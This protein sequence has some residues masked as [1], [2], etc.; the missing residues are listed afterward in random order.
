[1]VTSGMLTPSQRK[2]PYQKLRRS[3]RAT[4]NTHLEYAF[5]SSYDYDRIYYWENG[6]AQAALLHPQR[7]PALIDAFIEG[8]TQRRRALTQEE[9]DT[10]EKLWNGC[11][12]RTSG[13]AARAFGVFGARAP[14]LAESL[15]DI[16]NEGLDPHHKMWASAH[17]ESS[18]ETTGWAYLVDEAVLVLRDS[19]NK[20]SPKHTDLTWSLIESLESGA[21][22]KQKDEALASLARLEKDAHIIPGSPA[23]SLRET[24]LK[25]GANAWT[26]KTLQRVFA[27]HNAVSN[28]EI[29]DTT[30]H[31]DWTLGFFRK[32]MVIEQA[33][34]AL[35][36][37]R[38]ANIFKPVLDDILSWDA[39]AQALKHFANLGVLPWNSHLIPQLQRCRTP[40]NAEME[41]WLGAI[42]AIAA[43]HPP[44]TDWLLEQTRTWFQY[45]F[46]RLLT[47][48]KKDN[49]QGADEAG[50]SWIKQ[51]GLIAKLNRWGD[52]S[53]TLISTE[54]LK[55]IQDPLLAINTR[56]HDTLL[57]SLIASETLGSFLLIVSSDNPTA[58]K[59]MPWRTLIDEPYQQWWDA[60]KDTPQWSTLCQRLWREIIAIEERENDF[61]EGSE[62]KRLSNEM[63][64]TL[65]DKS[66]VLTVEESVDLLARAVA[67][68]APKAAQQFISDETVARANITPHFWAQWAEEALR[69]KEGLCLYQ[70]GTRIIE[71]LEIAVDS[72]LD[73]NNENSSLVMELLKKRPNSSLSENERK[74]LIETAIKRGARIP[75]ATFSADS[76]NELTAL[77]P[78]FTAW[79]KSQ[80]LEELPQ[81]L[82]NRARP[83]L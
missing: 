19:Q 47:E 59:P 28:E 79:L 7:G 27:A 3:G 57:K 74:S 9:R 76:E 75:E 29:L 53:P 5:A 38:T 77:S 22:M 72:G 2:K 4:K 45:S 51:W 10:W 26:E 62:L 23:H 8:F 48:Q 55:D 68:G 24:L 31:Q 69:A 58:W 70:Q 6:I 21:G 43:Q 33:A 15:L 42:V 61:K 71:I 64:N 17:L 80:Q 44:P 82:P 25:Q 66:D 46:R 73:P 63:L 67:H 13:N 36:T 30:F 1:M 18:K 11:P 40:N 49:S 39:P 34:N 52:S 65:K 81:S 20:M 50:A 14:D 32:P 83:R 12:Y 37:S 41:R 54:L 60:A 35:H 16:L 56:S 78:L